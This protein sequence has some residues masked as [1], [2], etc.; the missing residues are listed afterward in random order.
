MKG[1]KVV[2]AVISRPVT[3]GINNKWSFS[4]HYCQG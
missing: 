1:V 4:S 3:Y 2:I